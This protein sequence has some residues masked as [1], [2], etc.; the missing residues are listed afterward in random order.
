M[1]TGHEIFT[2]R[3]RNFYGSGRCLNRICGSGGC[4]SAKQSFYGAGQWAHGK[5]KKYAEIKRELLWSR[6]RISS[7]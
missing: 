5:A 2:D 6:K 1:R 3:T 7:N 4:A